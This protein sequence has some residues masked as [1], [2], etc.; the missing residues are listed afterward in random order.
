MN[1]YENITFNQFN[2]HIKSNNNLLLQE[3]LFSR[4]FFLIENMIIIHSVAI[5]VYA[6]ATSLLSFISSAIEPE[7]FNVKFSR[8]HARIKQINK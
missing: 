6:S 7:Y 1:S 2:H 5:N 3:K 8:L 4:S